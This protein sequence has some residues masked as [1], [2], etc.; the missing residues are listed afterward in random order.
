MINL[1]IQQIVKKTVSLEDAK[2]SKKGVIYLGKEA[3]HGGESSLIQTMTKVFSIDTTDMDVDVAI[4]HKVEQVEAPTPSILPKNP[5][6]LYVVELITRRPYQRT[7][8][9]GK[10]PYLMN[11]L[12]DL[13][14]YASK[15]RNCERVEQTISV[16][17]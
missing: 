9:I 12:T 4:V 13:G 11:Y 3:S 16:F 8:L 10:L 5:E 14:M 7:F 15:P 17:F 1:H 2:G 6:G